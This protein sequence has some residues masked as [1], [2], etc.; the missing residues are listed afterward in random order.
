MIQGSIRVPLY[1]EIT[2]LSAMHQHP[3]HE[4]AVGP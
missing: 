3:E 1:R 4:R 2:A